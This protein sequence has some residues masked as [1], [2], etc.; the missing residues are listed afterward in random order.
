M[1][2]A[3]CKAV[4]L[5]FTQNALV[6]NLEK[7]EAVLLCTAQQSR[8]AALL[9]NE[10]S[11]AGC[12]VLLA[13]SVKILGVTM[14]QHSKADKLVKNVCQF[15]YYHIRALKHIGLSLSGDMARTVTGVIV[16][17]GLNYANSVPYG[18]STVNISRL[19]RVQN[20]L[21]RIVA[22]MKRAEHIH[23]ILHN[24]H[25]LPINYST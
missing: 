8:A 19:Q 25:W 21:A 5:P 12:V 2:L 22:Y 6:V 20:A 23:P 7:L 15:A 11:V 3:T 18:S 4:L 13:N 14:N 16:N 1:Q 10:V 17:S 9:L 24:I